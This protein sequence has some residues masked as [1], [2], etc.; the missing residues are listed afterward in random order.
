MPNTDPVNALVPV[1]V[2]PLFRLVSEITGASVSST[3][4]RVNGLVTLPARSVATMEIVWVP[5]ALPSRR[6]VVV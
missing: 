3:N 2:S 1:S 6:N 4:V 5:S